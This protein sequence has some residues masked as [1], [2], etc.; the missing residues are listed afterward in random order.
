MG[1]AKAGANAGNQYDFIGSPVE[2]VDHGTRSAGRS[3]ECRLAP[4]ADEANVNRLISPGRPLG[5]FIPP[6]NYCHS[7]VRDTLDASNGAD[8]FD[9]QS[10]IPS[11]YMADPYK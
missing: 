4:G 3:A 6:M 10:P 1:T 8:P 7:F 5:R 2:T 9:R 11:P